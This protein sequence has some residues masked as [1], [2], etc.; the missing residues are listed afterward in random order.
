MEKNK[1]LNKE[2]GMN[3]IKQWLEGKAI[4]KL[5]VGMASFCIFGGSFIALVYNGIISVPNRF[6]FTNYTIS[7]FAVGF[8]LCAL[9]VNIPQ[10]VEKGK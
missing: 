4:V 1:V 10:L 9:L 3:K 8:A 2:K 6:D 7:V 5:N